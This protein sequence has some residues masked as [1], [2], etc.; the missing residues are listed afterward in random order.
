MKHA[1]SSIREESKSP[2]S[3]I[4]TPTTSSSVERIVIDGL[5]NSSAEQHL[6]SA[7]HQT[8]HPARAYQAR[9][10]RT[11]SVIRS[12]IVRPRPG[13]LRTRA[14]IR[15]APPAPKQSPVASSVS[16]KPSAASSSTRRRSCCTPA[17]LLPSPHESS[18]FTPRDLDRFDR[19][20]ESSGQAATI[21]STIAAASTRTWEKRN[22]ILSGQT[23]WP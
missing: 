19:T 15:S 18:S 13:A 6:C 17:Q 14:T 2:S 10:L 20:F 12:R 9:K 11:N 23:Q 5:A 8:A 4:A 16:Q 22:G 21:K 1:N 3:I 7:P